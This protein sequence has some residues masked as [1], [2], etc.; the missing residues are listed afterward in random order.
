MNQLPM[1]MY[2]AVSAVRQQ[3]EYPDDQ[4]DRAE[5]A[6]PAPHRAGAMLR[7]RAATASSLSRLAAAIAPTSEKG[8]AELGLG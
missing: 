2:L 8:I 5:S 7:A 4:P 1:A 6:A 3:F